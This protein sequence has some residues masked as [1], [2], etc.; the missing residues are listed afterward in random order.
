[1][2]YTFKPIPYYVDFIKKY[3]QNLFTKNSYYIRT[4]IY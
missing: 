4:I 2:D 3:D 1:M